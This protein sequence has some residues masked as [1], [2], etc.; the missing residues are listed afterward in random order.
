MDFINWEDKLSVGVA[1]IDT[2][3][4]KLIS[5]INNLNHAIQIKSSTKTLEEI[6][7]SLIDYTKFHFGH[8]EKLLQQ[9]GYAELP[10]HHK[11]HEELTA[12]VIDFHERLSTG[13]ASFTLELM[14]FLRDWLINHIMKT[15]M[16]Y[17]EFFN[18]KGIK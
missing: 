9:N 7:L 3:H 1:E 17:K 14:L 18:S 8:E 4:K 11:E 12:K 2:E 16:Q 13:K 5:L 10:Q 6:L 15:D